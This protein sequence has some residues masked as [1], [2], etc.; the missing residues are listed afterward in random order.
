MKNRAIAILAAALVICLAPM[1]AQALAPFATDF[2]SYDVPSPGALMGDGWKVFGNVFGYDW[3]YWYGYGPFDAPND[4]AAFCAIATGQGMGYKSLSVYSDYNNANH[5]DGIVE[6][7]VFQEQVIGPENVGQMW[8][9]AFRAK[10]GNLAE[11]S[12]AAAFIKTLDPGAGYATTNYIT[13]DMTAIPTAWSNYHIT[14]MIDASLEGQILQFGFTNQAR[15]YQPSGVFYD[16][17]QFYTDSP[18]PAEESSW[19]G[20]KA[21]FK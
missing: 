18:I 3:S 1:T 7:N 11:M 9:F 4:G 10:L 20:V 13:E 19:G 14:I 21:L 2:E 15:L 12:N 16:N 5:A 17:A 8:T 6:S